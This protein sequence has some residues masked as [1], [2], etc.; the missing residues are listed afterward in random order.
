MQVKKTKAVRKHKL[1]GFLAYALAPIR[2]VPEFESK[3]AGAPGVNDVQEAGFTDYLVRRFVDDNEPYAV[4]CVLTAFYEG[5]QLFLGVGMHASR[6]R[7]DSPVIHKSVE[8]VKIAFLYRA[9]IDPLAFD[10]LCH[11]NSL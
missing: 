4:V 5:L 9:E 7:E 2:L 3:V 10:V 6:V 11:V 8:F 1:R